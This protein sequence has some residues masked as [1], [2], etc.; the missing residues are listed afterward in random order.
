MTRLLAGLLALV[1]AALAWPASAH[2]TPNSEIRL[3]FEPGALHANVLIPEAEYRF[4]TSRP[5]SDL[6]GLR[7]YLLSHTR[8]VAPDDRPWTVALANLRIEPA[9]GGPDILATL[10]YTPPPGASDRKLTLGWDAVIRESDTHFALVALE[11]DLARGIGEGNELL[12]TFTAGQAT[13][14]LDRGAAGGGALLLGAVRL[15]AH[16][17]LEGHDHL[18]FLLALLL[19]AP[20]LATGGRWG[21]V[22]PVRATLSG[23]AWIVTAFTLGHSATLILAAAFGAHLPTAPVEVAI[24]LSVLVSAIHAMRPVFPGRE[25]VVAFG[26]GL[27]H[28]LAFATVISGF[29]ATASARATAILGFNLGIE[30][31]QLALVGLLLP[32]LLIGSR[33]S[34]F[35]NARLVLAGFAALAAATWIAQ[36]AFGVADA[37]AAAFARVLPPLG[38]GLVVLS[39]A[40][41]LLALLPNANRFRLKSPDTAN[42]A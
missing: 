29:G 25:R 12:G 20:L 5:A 14:A 28:G 31:V 41:G 1:L 19:P 21:A 2:L 27:V 24:A 13:I 22:R 6:A 18:L 15:G 38:A 42:K 9:P 35:G 37:L 26:F 36:R 33:K 30:A 4:A 3:R 40:A 34:W 11:G 17:I 39:L 16:H 23:L 8:A 32:A 7:P 10:T